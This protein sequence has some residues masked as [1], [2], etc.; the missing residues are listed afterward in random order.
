[1]R[2]APLPSNTSVAWLS[3]YKNAQAQFPT[4]QVQSINAPLHQRFAVEVIVKNDKGERLR[5]YFNPVNGEYQGYGSWYNWQTSLRRLHRHLMLPLNWGLTLVTL[6]AFIFLGL[7]ISGLALHKHWLS[8]VFRWP[9]ISNTRV[10]WGDLHRLLGLWSVWIL[11]I[12]TLTGFWY[13]A[14]QWGLK[15]D[16]PKAA[17]VHVALEKATSPVN[18][19]PSLTTLE[20]ML[21]K[22]QQLRPELSIKRIKFNSKIDEP[23]LIEGQD[24]M[25]LV[26]DRANNLAFDPY[27][28]QQVSSRFGQ[29]LSLHVRISE[30]ADPLHF[31]TW[32]G[33]KSKI[34][35][36]IFGACLSAV[37]LSGTYIF[38]LRVQKVA[39]DEP[40]F[41]LMRWQLAWKNMGAIKGIALLLISTAFALLS[42]QLL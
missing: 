8:G 22:T 23:V 2:S 5:H 15:A 36:F 14:E 33:Y 30:A 42:Y 16:Y 24:Q 26:R 27:S 12:M 41:T 20:Q 3:I 11:V 35:Y 32:G 38:A 19:V 7:L 39:R 10:F 4:D 17:K 34:L 40:K 1:M 31:G 6:S 37:A 29:A 25:L 13:L 28:G 9:R 18:H 21:I